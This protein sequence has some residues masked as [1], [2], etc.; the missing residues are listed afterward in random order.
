MPI[1][2]EQGTGV[3]STG[4]VASVSKAFA[5]NV[6][7]ESLILSGGVSSAS[8]LGTTSSSDTRS[9]TYTRDANATTAGATSTQV[10]IFSTPKTSAGSCTVTM[11]PSGNDVVSIGIAEFSGAVNSSP[12]DQQNTGSGDVSANSL[13]TGN[14]T[15]TIRDAIVAIVSHGGGTVSITRDSAFT[16]IFQDTDAAD[17]P[18]DWCYRIADPATLNAS[19][20]FG[21]N[22]T[23]RAGAVA[24]YKEMD[25]PELRGTPDGLRGQRQVVQ[26]LAQ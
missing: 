12:L 14:I 8:K 22:V 17:M 15:T 11:D 2:F 20:T 26:L 6:L 5:S 10:C 16:Q 3:Q 9:N 7:A 23:F 4:S 1:K 13:A 18:I 19:W 21:S 24:A 25:Y